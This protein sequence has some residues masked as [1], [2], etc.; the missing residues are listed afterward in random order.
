M[1][2]SKKNPK[3][4]APKPAT[5]KSTAKSKDKAPRQSA[6][7]AR[8]EV[9]AR[10]AATKTAR[11]E[12]LAEHF[13]AG[14]PGVAILR[15]SQITTAMFAVATLV[16]VLVNSPFTR[17]LVIVVDLGLFALGMAVFVVAL[18]SGAQRSRE[19][20]MTM[21]GWWFLSGSAPVSVRA[22]LWGA[23][24]V[25]TVV[26]IAGA[27]IRPFTAL[28]FGVLVPTLGLAMCGL[29]GAHHALFPERRFR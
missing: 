21:A 15:G 2:A 28:A 10:A 18:Y 14:V 4:P 20:D 6:A 27:A 9:E 19:A 8:A 25:Q 5:A 23:V 11:T 22:T 29:W 17:T 3:K 24:A 12:A 26:A 13:A 16:A 1:S 7:E